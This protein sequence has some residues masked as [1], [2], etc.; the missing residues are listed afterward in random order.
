MTDWLLATF[1]NA[2]GIFEITSF[3]EMCKYIDR[4]P[5]VAETS[6]FKKFRKAKGTGLTDDEFINLLRIIK[7]AT[8]ERPQT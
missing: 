7:T 3:G 8:P 4:F 6:S 2:H 5:I 1:L